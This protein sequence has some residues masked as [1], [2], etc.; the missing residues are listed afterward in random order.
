MFWRQILIPWNFGTGTPRGSILEM[1]I[2]SLD[3]FS[4][5]KQLKAKGLS[6]R[7]IPFQIVG[8]WK[9]CLEALRWT[10]H[11]HEWYSKFW[12]ARWNRNYK[13]EIY[14]HCTD[15]QRPKTAYIERERGMREKETLYVYVGVGELQRMTYA[16]PSPIQSRKQASE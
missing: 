8:V 15:M 6:P 16:N 9:I 12:V 5:V 1:F 14:Q 3:F 2:E 13:I 10:F 11:T 4:E 7:K